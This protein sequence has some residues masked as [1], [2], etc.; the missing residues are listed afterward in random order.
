MLSQGG[1]RGAGKRCQQ[2]SLTLVLSTRTEERAEGRPKAFGHT[3]EGAR[4]SS[5]ETVHPAT[6]L[7]LQRGQATGGRS[8]VD[9]TP[10]GRWSADAGQPGYLGDFGARS[11]EQQGPHPQGGG[12]REVRGGVVNE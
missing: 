10:G 3:R 2:A 1:H 7:G 11:G 8:S 5:S 4:S 9:L 12:W 6:E